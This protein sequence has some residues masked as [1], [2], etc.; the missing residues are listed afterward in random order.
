MN[1]T[2]KILKE[3][4]FLITGGSSGVGKTAA[5]ELAQKGAKIVIT[6]GQHPFKKW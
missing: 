3:K 4:V 1:S 5:I 2:S 6:C